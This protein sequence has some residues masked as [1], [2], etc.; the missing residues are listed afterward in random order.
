MLRL[1]INCAE[2]RLQLALCQVSQ[3]SQGERS[4]EGEDPPRL[5]AFQEWTVPGQAN[6]VLAPAVAQMLSV[7]S[8]TAKDLD[9]VACVT[10]PGSFTGL[11]MSLAFAEGLRAATGV[12]LAGLA[13]LEL[14]ACAAIGR[15]GMA[16]GRLWVMT[17]ART[18]LCYVQAFEVGESRATNAHVLPL[19]EALE[20]AMAAPGLLCGSALRRPEAAAAVTHLLG[21]QPQCILLPPQFDTPDGACLLDSALEAPYAQASLEP[22]YMRASDAEDNLEAI[23]RAKGLD[24][25][26]ARNTFNSL[27]SSNL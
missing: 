4:P 13:Y 22:D 26:A 19:Q 14:L 18:G 5:L 12:P 1:V 7:F 16:E 2:E 21:T 6:T 17:S 15:L 23:A 9:G 20:Q 25:D 11:R 8:F 3:M 24:P 27:T 10:G